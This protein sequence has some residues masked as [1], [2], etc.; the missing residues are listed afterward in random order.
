MKHLNNGF[1]FQ[2]S[3]QLRGECLIQRILQ[4]V[5]AEQVKAFVGFKA[6]DNWQYIPHIQVILN[7]V[8]LVFVFVF[9]DPNVNSWRHIFGIIAVAYLVNIFAVHTNYQFHE[10]VADFLAQGPTAEAQFDEC[11]QEST[12]KKI[13]GHIRVEFL[14][15]SMYSCCKFW[16]LDPVYNMQVV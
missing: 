11:S 7:C 5:T 1:I 16:I 10:I 12:R 15:K 6:W 2:Y 3:Q 13:K 14:R 4:C 8:L 9:L